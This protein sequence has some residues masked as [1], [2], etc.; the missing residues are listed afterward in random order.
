[1]YNDIQENTHLVFLHGLY[2]PL[3]LRGCTLRYDDLN[4]RRG[5]S[6]MAK[7]DLSK[8]G[9]SGTTEIV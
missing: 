8:Y 3:W 9:I 6:I 4:E 1:M 2:S 5:I 7:L